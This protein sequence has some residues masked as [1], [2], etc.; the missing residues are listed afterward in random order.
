MRMNGCAFLF[1]LGHR[2]SDL[3]D[4]NHQYRWRGI[5]SCADRTR[6]R[7]C[8]VCRQDA[9]T[10]RI[11]TLEKDEILVPIAE[12]VGGEVWY[13]VRTK[14]GLT[15]WVRAIDVVI[16][17]AAKDNFGRRSPVRPR[18]APRS[19]EGRIFSG[20]WSVAPNATSESAAGAWTLNGANGTTTMRGTVECGQTLDGL[21][22][23]VACQLS[24][25]AKPSIPGV[26]PLIFHTCATAR[27]S[28][29]ICRRGET[30][31]QRFVDRRQRIRKLVH[32][33]K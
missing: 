20:T 7:R 30:G 9:E 33:C 25:A 29:S 2:A 17:N 13:M 15:G 18:G 3:A 10:D 12:S 21:E 28:E 16:S 23:R 14:R 8:L 4:T 31:D 1:R 26:G 22:W 27:L 24:K 19:S 32:P 5:G 6:N 11:A